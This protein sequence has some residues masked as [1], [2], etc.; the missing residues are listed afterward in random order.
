MLELLRKALPFLIRYWK[1][2]LLVA[3]IA[4]LTFF[5]HDGNTLKDQINVKDKAIIM[6]QTQ[7]KQSQVQ[8]NQMANERAQM[9]KNYQKS[10]QLQKKVEHVDPKDDGEVAPILRNILDELRNH[11]GHN[12]D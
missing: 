6:A 2:G 11:P 8:I 9:T 7:L 12:Q 3:L 5:V 10:R 1:E 4:A